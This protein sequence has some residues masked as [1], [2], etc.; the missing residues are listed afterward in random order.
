M[1]HCL[2]VFSGN[3]AANAI[4]EHVGGTIPA[5][6]DMMNEY[7]AKLGCTGTHFV[8]AHG[9]QN[10]DH[11]TTPYD[12][13]LILKEAA[14]FP[15][16]TEISQMPSYTL[17]YKKADGTVGVIYMEATDHY[18]TGEANLPRN[19]SVLGGKTGI[20]D[21]AGNCLALLTTNAYGQPFVSIVMGAYTKPEL[22]DQ[23]NTLLVT[24]NNQG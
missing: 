6:V 24:T 20:T 8:N 21:E 5:F 7:A 23:M 2:L 1:L 15:A 4:A 3:D 18:L 19:V 10:E 11:Y 22:Y 17:E 14:K 12:I 13:Y 9:L 16:F